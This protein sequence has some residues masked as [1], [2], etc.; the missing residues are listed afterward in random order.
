MRPSI[1]EL[2]RKASKS[3]DKIT[4]VDEDV[5][6]I[7]RDDGIVIAW[8]RDDAITVASEGSIEMMECEVLIDLHGDDKSMLP[9]IASSDGVRLRIGGSPIFFKFS[10]FGGQG[11]MLSSTGTGMGMG[12]GAGSAI[13]GAD[14]F[15]SNIVRQQF[16]ISLEMARK[17]RK[18]N[19]WDRSMEKRLQ[20]NELYGHQRNEKDHNLDPY[21][22][23]F[24]ERRQLKRRN[25]LKRRQDN[26]E[27]ARKQVEGNS[28]KTIKSIATDPIHMVPL[29][30]RLKDRRQ[31]KDPE[32]GF[33]RKYHGPE[34]EFTHFPKSENPIQSG[35]T[36]RISANN[37]YGL[38][39]TFDNRHEEEALAELLQPRSHRSSPV[40]GKRSS[41]GGVEAGLSEILRPEGQWPSISP[42]LS[43]T[44]IKD[45]YFGGRERLTSYPT[46]ENPVGDDRRPDQ[47]FVDQKLNM[48]MLFDQYA[49]SSE[50]SDNKT[51]LL[52]P[53]ETE[54]MALD[55]KRKM[56]PVRSNPKVGVEKNLSKLHKAPPG[57]PRQWTGDEY[58][59]PAIPYPSYADESR[60][61]RNTPSGQGVI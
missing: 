22:M 6:A 49:T 23:T 39:T 30:F 2:L 37:Q 26:L 4:M 43:E 54:Q 44:P 1:I 40:S 47:D 27:K 28:V 21:T 24:N 59:N 31:E 15:G 36:I 33:K 55:I 53:V 48:P 45:P 57:Y 10:Q 5:Y 42:S 20:S 25:Y 58:N 38:N 29:E 46:A 52:S 7:K 12:P 34:S 11:G 60:L 13:A 14:Q 61:M 19:D 18:D 51:S 9:R 56:R 3:S 32:P 16:D 8:N 35:P 17:E 41:E 50:P